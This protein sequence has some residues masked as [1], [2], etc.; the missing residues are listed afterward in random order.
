MGHLPLSLLSPLPPNISVWYW[1][2]A[3]AAAFI[4][5]LVRLF[6]RR[7]PESS[8][9]A[10]ACFRRSARRISLSV[11]VIAILPVTLRLVVLGWIPP[12][13]PAVHDEFGHLL[14]AGT[15]AAGR[16]A[17][18]A[19]PLWRHLETI[20]VLHQPT[21]ASIYPI[22]PGALMA[23]GELLAGN[24]WAGVLLSVALMSGATA[25]MLFAC[26]PPT[27]ALLGGLLAALGYGLSPHWIDSYWGGSLCAFGGALLFGS[28][29]RLG[30]RPS[31]TLAGIAG[32]GWSIVWFTRPFE[33][34][35]LLLLTGTAITFL[36]VRFRGPRKKWVDAILV[37]LA[38]QVCA[39]CITML[40]NH[41]VTRS[42]FTLPYKLSQTVYGVPQSLLWQQPIEEPPG[43]RFHEL[44][45]MYSWQR[46]AKEEASAHPLR[47]LSEVFSAAW[48]FYITPWYSLPLILLVVHLREQSVAI[49]V[50]TVI[51]ALTASAAYPYFFPHY[52]A[53]YACVVVFLIVRGMMTL[54][55]WSCRGV[56]LGSLILLFL[57]AGGL[58]MGLTAIPL[59]AIVGLSYDSHEGNKRV[60]VAGRLL[61]SGDRHVVFVSYSPDHSPQDEWVY[62]AAD[63]DAAPIVWCRAMDE[64]ADL[65]VIRYYKG[66]QFWIARVGN[67]AVK[68]SPY[69]FDGSAATAS[70]ARDF[71]ITRSFAE[72]RRE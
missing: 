38:I 11:L 12:P 13:V 29:Y 7:W 28:L 24:A 36:V 68:V 47:R 3:V 59:E 44:R 46:Q 62:N 52:V 58:M 60:R 19:H 70:H 22:G 67:D 26:L 10:I 65:E 8:N 33:S 35:F 31:R 48:S 34:L 61:Q 43:L 25:W 55:R 42:F 1:A 23:A 50:A 9:W 71:V 64:T 56:N 40:H 63:I 53:A 30:A 21:Y 39:G 15:L 32:L 6:V 41:A 72:E 4:T 16:L 5:A 37:I 69:P 18:P 51:A 27:W 66:R 49:G 2:V 57:V 45:E 17:N 20:Y 14:V 54:G